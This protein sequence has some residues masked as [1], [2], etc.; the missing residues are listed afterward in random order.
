MMLLAS[1]QFQ[2]PLDGKGEP[3]LRLD[4]MSPTLRTVLL[5]VSLG[6]F[7]FCFR[8]MDG[9]ISSPRSPLGLE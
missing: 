7:V 5:R 9:L 4:R 1:A 6:S 8:R 2:M 3:H